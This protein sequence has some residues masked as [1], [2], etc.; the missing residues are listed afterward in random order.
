[1]L[2]VSEYEKMWSI[3]TV[4]LK[5]FIIQRAEEGGV[6]GIICRKKIV[7]TNNQIDKKA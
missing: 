1:L 5:S 3:V 4:E 7:T 2:I 6:S